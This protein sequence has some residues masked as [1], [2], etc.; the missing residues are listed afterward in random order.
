M[1][2]PFSINPS[3]LTESLKVEWRRSDAQTLVHLYQD[4]A[5]VQQQDYHKRANFFTE[6][7]KDGEFSLQ[8]KKV[9]A[10]DAGE[11]TCT[12]YNGQDSAIQSFRSILKLGKKTIKL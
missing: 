8:L 2:V 7:I 3:L 10:E 6:K 12:V 9:K 4:G 1:V 11:Y 5:A